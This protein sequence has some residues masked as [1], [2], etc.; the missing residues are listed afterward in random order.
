MKNIIKVLIIAL[1]VTT[2]FQYHKNTISFKDTNIIIVSKN[3]TL[4]KIASDLN[5]GEHDNRKIV[6]VIKKINNL[7]TSIIK[8]GQHL[9]VPSI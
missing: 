4:W 5:N 2:I 9:I 1:L 6:T 7:D 8:P 3:D